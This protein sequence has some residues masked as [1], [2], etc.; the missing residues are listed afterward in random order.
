MYM[1]YEDPLVLDGLL[2]QTCRCAVVGVTGNIQFTVT[3]EFGDEPGAASIMS[4]MRNLAKA[5]ADQRTGQSINLG[6]IVTY[7][8]PS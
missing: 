1:T 4:E 3:R 2:V 8:A 7:C 5:E 6:T